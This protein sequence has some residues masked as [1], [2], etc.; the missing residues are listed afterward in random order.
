MVRP[1]KPVVVFA[2]AVK[3]GGRKNSRASTRL[4]GRE[5]PE[6]HVRDDWPP[7]ASEEEHEI[8]YLISGFRGGPGGGP[9]YRV[10]VV[11]GDRLMYE[12]ESSLV[13]DLGTIEAS[14]CAGCTPC[15]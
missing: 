6:G 10:S 11:N 2:D 13:A 15:P 8:A 14:R 12:A 4:E 7:S 5:V 9:R 3:S 1:T